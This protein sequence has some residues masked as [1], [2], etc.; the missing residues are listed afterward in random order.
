[1]NISIKFGGEANQNITTAKVGGFLRIIK[2]NRWSE[3]KVQD[4]PVLHSNIKGSVSF[5]RAG[6]ETRGT[7]LYI[8][9]KDNLRLDTISY[10]GVKGFP[11]FGDVINGKDVVSSLNSKYGDSTMPHLDDMYIRKDVFN[12]S[13]PGLDIIRKVYVLKK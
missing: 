10:D 6:K 5:T 4:E 12:K 13:F 8:N 7:E 3:S 9:L 11:S 1:M 2:L